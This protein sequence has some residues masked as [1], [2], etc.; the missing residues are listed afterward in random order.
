VTGGPFS[1]SAPKILVAIQDGPATRVFGGIV[2]DGSITI[3]YD[4]EEV[5][6]GI[7]VTRVPTGKKTVRLD[8]EFDAQY[9]GA[10]M[11]TWADIRTP[12]EIEAPV[13]ELGGVADG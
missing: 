8:V 11:K 9:I 10:D 1:S 2:T 12:E 7:Y 4:H 6:M 13:R 3:D 5:P